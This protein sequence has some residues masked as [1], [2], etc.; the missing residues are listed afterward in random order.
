MAVIIDD[1]EEFTRD[2][3]WYVVDQ[4]G[5]IGHFTN[6][7]MRT[8]PKSVKNDREATE[9]I[10]RYFFEQAPVTGGWSVRA[11][12][13]KDCGGWERQ[14]FE[15]YVRDFALMATKGLFS[16]DTDLVGGQQARYY[17]VAIPERPLHVSDL[18]LNIKEL[19]SR[20]ASSLRLSSCH[21]I[22]GQTTEAW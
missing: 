5:H 1:A 3:D 7:G 6:A 19:V 22:A 14:G 11:A 17:L 16:F 18:P 9:L 13:E 12:A 8:L 15:R 10:A 20:T 2:W 4:D 21:Y